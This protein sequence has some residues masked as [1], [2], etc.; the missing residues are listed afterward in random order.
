M[1]E[2]TKKEQLCLQYIEL[3]NE[4]HTLNNEPDKVIEL[5]DE[6]LESW[7][8][9]NKA[10]K[11]K[12]GEW[13]HEIEIA[14]AGIN[15]LKDELRKNAWFETEDGKAYKTL[16]ET[17]KEENRQK[18]KELRES[19]RKTVSDVIRNYLGDGWEVGIIG[20]TQTEVRYI[21]GYDEEGNPLVKRWYTFSIGYPSFSRSS[22]CHDIERP[23]IMNYPTC[24]SWDL[25][26]DDVMREYLAGLGKFGT[27]KECL[28]KLYSIIKEYVAEDDKLRDRDYDIMR[29]LNNPDMPEYVNLNE[30]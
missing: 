9:K 28:K 26:N 17:K 5:T 12:I 30:L 29:K 24:G 10:M 27:D 11:N 16:W 2:L 13:K 25:F 20:N 6:Y 3:R 7:K 1:V 8:F 21:K 19:T 15:A 4:Y 14:I 22:L 18:E 23:F